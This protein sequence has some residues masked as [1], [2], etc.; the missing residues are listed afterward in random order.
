MIRYRC[1]LCGKVMTESTDLLGG[2]RIGLDRAAQIVSMLCEGMSVLAVSRLTET[3][4]H[5]IID[6]VNYLGERCE[7]FMQEKIKGVHVEEIQVDE[8]WQFVLCKKA[9][10][11]AKKYVGGC[12]DSYVYVA[13][14]RGTKMIVTWH[15]GKRDDKHTNAFITKL[16]AATV[17]RFHLA[18][19]GWSCYPMAVW[20]HLGERVDYGMLVKIYG[21]NSAEDQR[22]Y[23]PARII[24]A[25]RSRIIGVPERSRICTSHVE[26]F[27]GSTRT[28]C[29][30]MARL[31]YAFSK[32]W[33][34]H[35]SALSLY[36]CHYNWCRKHRSLKGQTPAMA[37]GLANEAW[38]VK[39]LLTKVLTNT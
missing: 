21:D 6:I 38:S 32:K 30:R 34:N 33:N 36:F 10:A 25:K 39:E 27:N 5:T 23:S 24:E 1:K 22:R 3:D 7:V 9:T 28:F 18:S 4:P 8:Q 20:K 14:E 12:G 17:G 2:M 37:H 26:R 13:I 15:M 11:K 31:T 35:R 29:K 19:D 16:A